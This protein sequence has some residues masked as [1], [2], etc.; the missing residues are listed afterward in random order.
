MR[1][2]DAVRVGGSAGT[3]GIDS[4]RTKGLIAPM[5]RALPACLPVVLACLP[6][7]GMVGGA[8]P[9]PEDPGRAAVLLVGSRGTA[10]TGVALAPRLVLTAAHCVLP[11][12]DYKLVA[13][14]AAR[15]PA[16]KDITRV[17]R[18]PQFDAKA[19]QRH[20]VSADVALLEPTEML[21]NVPARL[22]PA[23]AAVAVGD[24][25]L[26]TGYGA[27]VQGDG[28]SAGTLRAAVLVATGKPGSLQ[29]RLYDPATQG[30]APGLGACTGDSGAP[31][32]RESA[33]S[34]ALIGVVSWSTGPNNSGGCGGL[35]GVTPLTR[36]RGWIVETAARMGN[37]LP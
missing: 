12:A 6:A 19:A 32:Y 4:A 31:V 17:A 23:G 36:Y 29:V 15:R 20:R 13:F 28:K 5:L 8:P 10:C 37:P 30:K 26:V 27:A 21:A 35:T 16:L 11:G 9:A 18:H 24:R 7:A 34:F 14:D 2:G 1:S 3:A 22:A 33:G 25:F